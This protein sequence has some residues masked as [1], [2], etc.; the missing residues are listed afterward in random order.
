M[1][2]REGTMRIW[3]IYTGTAIVAAAT[4]LA[5]GA[6]GVKQSSA[7]IIKPTT[8]YQQCMREMR[9]ICLEQAPMGSPEHL[10]CILDADAWCEG[11]YG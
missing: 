1:P 4:V 6:T 9:A 11:H 10:Q 5:M 2:I 8:P 3:N 7:Q